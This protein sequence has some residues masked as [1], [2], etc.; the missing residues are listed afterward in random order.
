VRWLPSAI[1]S[2][3]VLRL[4]GERGMGTVYQAE[5]DHPRRTVALKV[6]RPEN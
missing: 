2:Y 5:Q 1:G 4:V 6:I 3:R